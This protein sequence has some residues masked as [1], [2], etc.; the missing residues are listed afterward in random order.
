MGGQ[1]TSK[2][3][4]WAFSWGSHGWQL[5]EMT[6]QFGFS[7]HVAFHSISLGDMKAVSLNATYD[8]LYRSEKVI[9][10]LRFTG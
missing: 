7:L 4:A 10:L 8:I 6:V 9:R 1:G 5:S 3:L 2:G